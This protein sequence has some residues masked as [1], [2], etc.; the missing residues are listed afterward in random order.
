MNNFQLNK[1]N[2]KPCLIFPTE[3]Y[4]LELLSLNLLFPFVPVNW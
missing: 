1:L 2:V 3:Q 4:A